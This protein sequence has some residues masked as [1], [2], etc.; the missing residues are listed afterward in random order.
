M[1]AIFND[2]LLIGVVFFLGTAVGALLNSMYR[3]TRMEQLKKEL[4]QQV[5]DELLSTQRK[6][7][8]TTVAPLLWAQEA[9]EELVARVEDAEKVEAERDLRGLAAAR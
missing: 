3:A 9:T 5:E 4:I 1:D 6:E 7:K 2:S 8:R